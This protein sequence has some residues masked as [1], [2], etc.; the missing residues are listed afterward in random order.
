MAG[1]NV[2]LK[3]RKQREFCGKC[4]GAMTGTNISYCKSCYNKLKRE[5]YSH[6]R[7][8]EFLRGK[9]Y[10]QCHGRETVNR[11]RRKYHA[12]E[13]GKLYKKNWE[14]NNQE[15]VKFYDAQKRHKRRKEIANSSNKL[16]LSEWQIIKKSQNNKC[17]YCKKICKL[18]MDHVIPLSKGGH[19]TKNNIVGA[20]RLCNGRKTNKDP[21]VWAK[22]IGRLII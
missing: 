21:L 3:K 12:T 17:Y 6:N 7:E 9:K 8:R 18:T 16:T 15:K 4:L 5:W 22:E 2:P 13:H 20:C 11:L 19:H 14:K 10:A 1:Q